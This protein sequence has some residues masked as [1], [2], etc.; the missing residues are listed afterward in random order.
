PV[1][2]AHPDRDAQAT[3]L[4]RTERHCRGHLHPA[5]IGVALSC[6]EID[7]AAKACRIPGGEEVLRRSGAR[8]PGTA[9]L[10]RHGEVESYDAV[11][12]FRATVAAAARC[13]GLGKQRSDSVHYPRS[14]NSRMLPSGSLTIA[15]RRSGNT[16][17]SG[18][19]NS[20]PFSLSTVQTPVR[21]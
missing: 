1:L 7:R 8:P 2:D 20:T 3:A 14:T 19:V 21:S 16:C 5:G 6:D 12:R 17:V 13:R 4:A 11:A 15:I 9:H 10:R 18:M